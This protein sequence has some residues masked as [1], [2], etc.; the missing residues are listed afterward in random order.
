MYDD[1]E[2]KDNP[3][4]SGIEND[5]H[6]SEN[7]EYVKNNL[8]EENSYNYNVE[9]E[10]NYWE[11]DSYDETHNLNDDYYVDDNA[12][13]HYD[14][15]RTYHQPNYDQGYYNRGNG[16][17]EKP[18]SGGMARIVSLAL[19]FSIIGSLI[20]GAFSARLMREKYEGKV[21]SEVTGQ[22]SSYTINTNDNI[23]TVA[24]VAE[25]T[26]DKVVGVST[27][28]MMRD[29][30]NRQYQSQGTGS[31]VI[32]DS[33]GYILTNNH[34]ISSLSQNSSFYGN[35]N[36]G[37]AFADDI[38][39]VF[40]DGSQLPAQVIWADNNMDLA[41]LKVE[42]KQPLPAAKLGDS[43][44]L[45]IGEMA[46]AIGN[47]FA[48][49]FHGTVTAGYIS[50]LNRNLSAGGDTE[51]DN[52]IQTDASINQGN[53]GGPLLNAKGEVIGIN[54]MKITAGEGMGFSIPINTAKPVIEQIIETGNF[55]RVAL[56]VSGIDIDSYETKMGVDLGIDKGIIVINI[57]EDSP[58]KVAD[59]RTNDII[60]QVDGVEVNTIAGLRRALTKYSIGDAATISY[61]RDGDTREV[62]VVF[63]TFNTN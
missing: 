33:R 62:E 36:Q 6:T 2:R 19:I 17:K 52:L 4:V 39:V 9:P 45:R 55:D 54:T 57:Y 42:P 40:N 7:G 50:G 34:V 8:H 37:P 12:Q 38:Q 27:T 58:A 46:I 59:L 30:F 13:G 31:G 21:T 3:E 51:M 16:H 56:G 1:Y 10:N 29:I 49:E 63:K 47:P 53:S 11:D 48:I 28:S 23:N 15:Q 18:K 5:I 14:E 43:D 24:A 41:M 61:V 22:T 26:L 44:K 32:V 25:A 60:T 35:N 20:G